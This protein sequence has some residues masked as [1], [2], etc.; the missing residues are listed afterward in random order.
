[1]REEGADIVIALSHSGID[2]EQDDDDGERVA[3]SSPASTGIDAVFTGHQHLVFPGN[4][5]FQDL[6]GVDA[7]KGTLQG[8][9]A[10][11]GGFWGS[12]MG[13][14]DMLLERDGSDV[15]GGFGDLRGAADLRA[16]RQAR[17]CRRS[18]TTRRSSRR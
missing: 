12:H 8:K 1:M 2:T 13:L 7:A 9:P 17:T 5:D 10:V 15:E 16:R 4:K 18:R 14:I 3:S 6:E 11:M